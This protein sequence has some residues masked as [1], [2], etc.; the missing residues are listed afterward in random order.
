MSKDRC[1]EQALRKNKLANFKHRI[2]ALLAALK[3]LLK[4][5]IIEPTFIEPPILYS[6]FIARLR[7]TVT[8]AP[9]AQMIS[10][11]NEEYFHTDALT[12]GQ[13]AVF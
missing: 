2:M 4:R 7:S 12:I 8:S 5:T 13:Y 10:N 9:D 3:R 11:V 1:A 6:V